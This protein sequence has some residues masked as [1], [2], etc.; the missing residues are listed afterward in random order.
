MSYCL[1]ATEAINYEWKLRHFLRAAINYAAANT[2]KLPDK[3]VNDSVENHAQGFAIAKGLSRCC[4]LKLPPSIT[5]FHGSQLALQ[6]ALSNV[7]FIQCSRFSFVCLNVFVL[8]D[9]AVAVVAVAAVA[10]S[11]LVTSSV[12]KLFVV[13]GVFARVEYSGNEPVSTCWSNPRLIS[14]SHAARSTRRMRNI[15]MGIQ[16][17]TATAQLLFM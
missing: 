4:N 9:V 8:I 14:Q 6:A 15:L 10:Q 13:S 17:A 12:I 11:C 3:R 2:E 5:D 7:K 1:T 16:S